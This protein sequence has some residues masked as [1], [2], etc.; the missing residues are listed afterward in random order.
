MGTGCVFELLVDEERDEHDDRE[1]DGLVEG[2]EYGRDDGDEGA[3]EG[4]TSAK[5][6]RTAKVRMKQS[7]FGFECIFLKWHCRVARGNRCNL[8]IVHANYDRIL[9]RVS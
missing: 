9:S 7:I 2:G 5:P 4:M 3:D 8:S 1:S 6:A